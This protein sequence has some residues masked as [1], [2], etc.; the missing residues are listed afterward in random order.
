MSLRQRLDAL[1]SQRSH[2]HVAPIFL[3]NDEVRDEL[4]YIGC[5]YG[6]RLSR[7]HDETRDEFR[8]RCIAFSKKH[9]DPQRY[10]QPLFM[11]IHL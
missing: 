3:P 9:N 5:D 1:E 8:Q 11:D 4:D 7:A 2:E 6:G 10:P